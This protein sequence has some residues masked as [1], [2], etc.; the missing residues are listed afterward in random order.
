VLHACRS[1]RAAGRDAK[2]GVAQT[3]CG[4]C[5]RAS[6]TVTYGSTASTTHGHERHGHAAVW[7]KCGWEEA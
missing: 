6:V 5:G 3:H 4:E 2:R 1:G 7:A